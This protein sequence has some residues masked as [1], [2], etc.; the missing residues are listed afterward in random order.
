MEEAHRLGLRTT[1]TMMFG[2]IETME[3]RLEHLQRVRDLQDRSSGFTAFIPWPLSAGSYAFGRST[4]DR[5]DHSCDLFAYAG[6][7]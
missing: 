2:H 7:H 5:E 6:I 3:E 1:A 4:Q